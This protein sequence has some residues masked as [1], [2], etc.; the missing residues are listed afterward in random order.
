[1]A[2]GD[3]ASLLSVDLSPEDHQWLA[4]LAQD[5]GVTVQALIGQAVQH[6]RYWQE[7]GEETLNEAL[8]IFQAERSGHEN[9]RRQRLYF[10]QEL[11]SQSRRL[12]DMLRDERHR[13]WEQ[14]SQLR[15]ERDRRIECEKQLREER[16][17][18]LQ[19]QRLHDMLRDERHRRWEQESQLRDERD[20]RIECENQLQDE[21]NRRAESERRLRGDRDDAGRQAMAAAADHDAPYDPTVAKLLALAIYSESGS[22]ATAAFAKARALHRRKRDSVSDHR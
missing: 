17:L 11:Q 3:R 22:E 15:D 14:E 6:F 9:E 20:R 2:D 19:A 18:R 13:R 10:Q 16:K 7:E 12:H 21:R 1:M 4:E 8:D 5:H